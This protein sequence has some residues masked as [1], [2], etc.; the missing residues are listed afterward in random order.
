MDHQRRQEKVFTKWCNSW[1]KNRFLEIPPGTLCSGSL[2][3]GKILWNLLSE[4]SGKTLP[5]LSVPKYFMRIH[6]L[7]NLSISLQFLADENIKLV[8]IAQEDILDHNVRLILGLVWT[9]ILRFQIAV[10]STSDAQGAKQ[11]LFEWVESVSEAAEQNQPQTE[12]NSRQPSRKK[13]KKEKSSLPD[14]AQLVTLVNALLDQVDPHAKRKLTGI[15]RDDVQNA[16]LQAEA[17]LGIAKIIDVDDVIGTNADEKFIMTYLSSLKQAQT[18]IAQNG[19]AHLVT[20]DEGEISAKFGEHMRPLTEELTSQQ[21]YVFKLDTVNVQ[22]PQNINVKFSNSETGVPVQIPVTIEPGE[23][24]AF[25]V[26]FTF[27]QST[28]KSPS[29]FDLVVK[30]GPPN[31]TSKTLVKGFPLRAKVSPT[32]FN[33]TFPTGA[34]ADVGKPFS[35]QIKGLKPGLTI[36]AES[37]A[38]P[39]PVQFVGDT[40][41]FIPNVAGNITCQ[42]RDSEGHPLV[43]S[44]FVV[45]STE[46]KPEPE[47][48]KEPIPEPKPEPEPQVVEPESSSSSSSSSEELPTEIPPLPAVP[49]VPQVVEPEQPS[50]SS[51]SSSEEPLPEPVV[52]SI[53]LNIDEFDTSTTRPKKGVNIQFLKAN[54]TASDVQI[55]GKDK[56]G[57]EVPVKIVDNSEPNLLDAFFTPLADGKI[58][59]IVTTNQ[60][61]L[62]DD[63][64]VMTIGQIPTVTLEAPKD[65][66]LIRKPVV[67]KARSNVN[68]SSRDDV[69]FK[70]TCGKKDIPCTVKNNTVSFVCTDAADLDLFCLVD[71]VLIQ[72][73]KRHIRVRGGEPSLDVADK[74]VFEGSLVQPET[75]Q[76]PCKNILK[77]DI[78]ALYIEPT[79]E[80]VEIENSDFDVFNNTLK[81]TVNPRNEGTAQLELSVPGIPKKVVL[82]DVQNKMNPR[83]TRVTEAAC[84]GQQ[85]CVGIDSLGAKVD[86]KVF[87]EIGND[88]PFK[89]LENDSVVFTPHYQGHFIVEARVADQIIQGCPCSVSVAPA[90]SSSAVEG[91][92]VVEIDT[93]VAPHDIQLNAVDLRT[94]IPGDLDDH[95]ESYQIIKS[96][97]N[98]VLVKFTPKEGE[99]LKLEAVT[100]QRV[101]KHKSFKVDL[102]ANE[103]EAVVTSEEMQIKLHADDT[104]FMGDIP[105]EIGVESN[106]P[107]AD[108]TIIAKNSFGTVLPCTL[109]QDKHGNLKASLVPSFP[110]EVVLSTFFKGEALASEVITVQEP[111]IVIPPFAYID[112]PAEIMLQPEFAGLEGLEVHLFQSGG[113]SLPCR[114]GKGGKIHFVP[115]AAGT[116]QFIYKLNGRIQG[117]PRVVPVFQ[118]L[119]PTLSFAVPQQKTP[120]AI[121]GSI[122]NIELEATNPPSGAKFEALYE[123]GEK[124]VLESS[125]IDE[126]G[127]FKIEFFPKQVGSISVRIVGTEKSTEP[128]YI[129]VLERPLLNFVFPKKRG[130]VNI[131]SQMRFQTMHV[132]QHDERKFSCLVNG[133]PEPLEFDDGQIIVNFTPRVKGSTTV[134]VQ[135]QR[136]DF[137]ST[138]VTILVDDPPF[139]KIVSC[140]TTVPVG[141]LVSI[142]VDSNLF[143]DNDS[144]YS[145]VVCYEDGT[146]IQH[147]LYQDPCIELLEFTPPKTGKINVEFRVCGNNIVGSPYL[148]EVIPFLT[149]APKKKLEAAVKIVSSGCQHSLI[150][151]NTFSTELALDNVKFEDINIEILNSNQIKQDFKIQRKPTGHIGLNFIPE[152]IGSYVLGVQLKDGSRS[153]FEPFALDVQMRGTIKVLPPNGASARVGRSCDLLLKTTNV[154]RKEMQ[155]LATFEQ[156][157]TTEL[158]IKDQFEKDGFTYFTVPFIPSQ[159]GSYFIAVTASP[160]FSVK[161]LLLKVGAAPFIKVVSYPE[162]SVLG[163]VVEIKLNSNIFPEDNL[164]ML[165]VLN[166]KGEPVRH[167]IVSNSGP[168]EMI[169]IVPSEE[170]PIEVNITIEGK[171]ILNAPFAIEITQPR[172]IVN[173]GDCRAIFID[174][175]PEEQ[176]ED[177]ILAAYDAHTGA[178][179][180]LEKFSF[181]VEPGEDGWTV[182]FKPKH[183]GKVILNAHVRG[184]VFELLTAPSV[185][186]VGGSQ[187]RSVLEGEPFIIQLATENIRLKDLKISVKDCLGQNVFLRTRAENDQLITLAGC[188]DEPGLALL[189]VT[190]KNHKA[191]HFQPLLIDIRPKPSMEFVVNAKARPRVN[192]PYTFMAQ[193]VNLPPKSFSVEA[194]FEDSGVKQKLEIDII[195]EELVEIS[196]CPTEIGFLTFQAHLDGK[197]YGD[198]LTLETLETAYC[199]P[200]FLPTICEKGETVELT[201][202]TNIRSLDD[203]V[204]MLTAKGTDGKRLP[205]DFQKGVVQ[206]VPRKVGKCF[207]ECSVNGK[208]VLNPHPH[209][210]EVSPPKQ[211]QTSSNNQTTFRVVLDPLIRLHDFTI[212]CQDAFFGVNLTES[213]KEHIL[214]LDVEDTPKGIGIAISFR[215][216]ALGVVVLN[217]IVKPKDGSEE[218]AV[219]L[220][221]PPT[222]KTIIR[223]ATPDTPDLK[224]RMFAE[225]HK[226]KI[227]QSYEIELEHVNI[228]IQQLKFKLV[229]PKGHI[230]TPEVTQ[231]KP[232]NLMLNFTPLNAGDCLLVICK[233]D[234]TD[235]GFY[236]LPVLVLGTPAIEMVMLESHAHVGTEVLVYTKISYLKLEVLDLVCVDT[237]GN[238]IELNLYRSGDHDFIISFIPM[239]TGKTVI[240]PMYEGKPIP[241]TFAV[242]VEAP[243]IQALKLVNSTVIRRITANAKKS[244]ND[245]CR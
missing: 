16:L 203:P 57:N 51:S 230:V 166:L 55:I 179:V 229:D 161:S 155:V 10:G 198:P 204:I 21:P 68:L 134:K 197:P 141:R 168:Y 186:V 56:L 153:I 41:T 142:R 215:P 169:E 20:P 144:S 243:A 162:R 223:D 42:L 15:L 100:S 137:L 221:P 191:I 80:Q 149:E 38:G 200:I 99:K 109:H 172:K 24:G 143:A 173:R 92:I 62:I 121:V 185:S 7:E 45:Q 8:G 94:G 65:M 228:D 217:A 127:K 192:I 73:T 218:Y 205:L 27:P 93:M 170:G 64:M 101:P 22:N 233:E 174:Q 177:M 1:L 199:T 17:I 183:Y 50:S 146:E 4:I 164:A 111:Q 242:K 86:V 98:K 150:F 43:G 126:D 95:L 115:K 125:A 76:I 52:P 117:S 194:T 77:T 178:P 104:L 135:S 188:C 133:T 225:G 114:I 36:T 189:S 58:Q 46:P 241:K 91:Q 226:A 165:Q 12:E 6:K 83:V 23:G 63:T 119:A 140:P 213:M 171:L 160:N 236:P 128:L 235:V 48:P 28:V 78:K 184:T 152:E 11:E 33:F 207:I 29:Q 103:I 40:I 176:P 71:E 35:T 201:F 88:I 19:L 53:C 116:L 13:D 2:D 157:N 219:N 9:I 156:I 66:Y 110:G 190:R 214:D 193:L 72:D 3:D 67:L 139:A 244:R 206:F 129:H 131:P 82:F 208:S 32:T 181:E 112:E 138:S 148:M 211:K 108:L 222:I 147:S 132:E 224:K 167:T 187:Q 196:F 79:G 18:N 113:A 14:A 124:V 31:V 102:L 159:V 231:V 59:F 74:T 120:S 238:E 69:K 151:G 216:A 96:A 202:N 220:L 44:S 122:F 237:E 136:F 145:V 245:R 26:H 234:G 49:H 81:I 85:V 25:Y 130:R 107:L 97:K 163:K 47:P 87:D 89:V 158:L 209:V 180:E 227:N 212:C 105:I 106:C 90:S 195:S 5:K 34:T 70:V 84:V 37:S 118:S 75:I 240:A 210:L 232:G 60:G 154:K 175:P 39:V 30:L 182:K 123:D 61:Q 239:A 54:L